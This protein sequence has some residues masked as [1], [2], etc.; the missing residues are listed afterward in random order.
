LTALIQVHARKTKHSIETLRLQF[1]FAEEKTDRDG[2]F[3]IEGLYVYGAVVNNGVMALE[4]LPT[5]A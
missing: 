4:D 3:Y 1:T 5:K 2:V